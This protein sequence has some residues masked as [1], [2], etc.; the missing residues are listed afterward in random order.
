MTE[1]PNEPEE[2]DHS[3]IEWHGETAG[4]DEYVFEGRCTDCG[5]DIF[6]S[7]TFSGRTVESDREPIEPEVVQH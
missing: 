4:V 7:Y 1:F 5:A 6:D 3:S 2:C